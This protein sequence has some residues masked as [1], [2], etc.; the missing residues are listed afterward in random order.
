M[1]LIF[2]K[3]D[4]ADFHFHFISKDQAHFYEYVISEFSVLQ[5]LFINYKL[6]E[7][8]LE[9]PED[10]SVI[11]YRQIDELSSNIKNY[12]FTKLNLKLA[13]MSK[14]TSF[15]ITNHLKHLIENK[16]ENETD[17]YGKIFFKIGKQYEKLQSLSSYKIVL[18][19]I[20]K[21]LNNLLNTNI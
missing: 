7:D 11:E 5:N 17:I 6:P 4:R 8:Y 14:R 16:N 13:I 9:M 1:I 19:G 20:F 2:K 21:F 3:I 18:K 12:F 15:L 10:Y